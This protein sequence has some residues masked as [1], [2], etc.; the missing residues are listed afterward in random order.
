MSIPQFHHVAI[1]LLAIIAGCVSRTPVNPSFPISA[2]QGNQILS[3]DT[4]HPKPLRRPLVIVGGF[5]D[6]GFAQLM[7][8]NDFRKYT[9]DDRV[10][11][12]T[13][14]P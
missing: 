5:F 3:T 9:H 13:L 1:L 7:L 6:P 2:D 10:I 14:G 4:A 8:A 12:V 11:G